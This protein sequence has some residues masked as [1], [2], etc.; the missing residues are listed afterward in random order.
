M[1]LLPFLAL[2][3]VLTSIVMIV[4]FFLNGDL[5]IRTGVVVVAWCAAAGW[6]QFFST[7]AMVAAAGLAV[8]TLL[9]IYLLV[10]WRLTAGP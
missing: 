9:A 2:L 6:A 5:G 7:S 3:A 4:L 8:Q 1:P 10:R